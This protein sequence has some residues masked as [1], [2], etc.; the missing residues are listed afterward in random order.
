M[1]AMAG[2]ELQKTSNLGGELLR[3][4]DGGE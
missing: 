4:F 1:K 2:E 3:A